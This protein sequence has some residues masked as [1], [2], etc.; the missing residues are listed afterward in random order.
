MKHLEPHKQTLIDIIN[1]LLTKPEDFSRRYFFTCNEIERMFY[2]MDIDNDAA[3]R[4]ELSN[5][6][7]NEWSTEFVQTVLPP[8]AESKGK[9]LSDDQ[10]ERLSEKSVFLTDFVKMMTGK[11][12]PE[13]CPD[14]QPLRIEWL[15]F[16]K[17]KLQ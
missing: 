16:I 13:H 2:E 15:N 11:R 3:A 7:D 14:L 17:G 12:I 9:P 6:I 8:I 10:I 5:M 1:K 4:S